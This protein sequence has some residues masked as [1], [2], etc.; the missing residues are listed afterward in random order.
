[1]LHTG[2]DPATKRRLESFLAGHGYKQSPV[3]F[4][5]SDWIFANVYANA[6]DSGDAVLAKR[7]RDAYVPYMESVVAFFETRSVEVVGREF[8]QV[9]SIQANRGR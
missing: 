9:L 4:D 3:T 5:N 8:S 6:I 7:V 1:M 2:A